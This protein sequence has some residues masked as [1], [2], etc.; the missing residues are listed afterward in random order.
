MT[1]DSSSISRLISLIVSFSNIA[2]IFAVYI[3]LQN[4][5]YTDVMLTVSAM[6]FS[7]LHHITA[8]NRKLIPF[9]LAREDREKTLLWLDRIFALTLVIRGILY[10]YYISNDAIIQYNAFFLYSTIMFALLCLFISDVLIKNATTTERRVVYCIF[11][12]MWHIV[13]FLCWFVILLLAF[14]EQEKRRALVHMLE[15]YINNQ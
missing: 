6:V 3:A 8:T 4:E 14:R 5:A 7:F 9:F 12:C 1:H 2:G 11:H 10:L 15:K 13:A